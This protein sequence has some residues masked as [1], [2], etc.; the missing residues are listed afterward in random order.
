MEKK[1]WFRKDGWPLAPEEWKTIGGWVVR[2]AMKPAAA[3]RPGFPV[4]VS[5]I[6][7]E[8]YPLYSF[9]SHTNWKP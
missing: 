1:K 8:L 4:D 9:S 2:R 5:K 6:F 3:T 7:R